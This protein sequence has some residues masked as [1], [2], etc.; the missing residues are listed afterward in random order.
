MLLSDVSQIFVRA[1]IIHNKCY[2]LRIKGA[3]VPEKYQNEPLANCCVIRP[4]WFVAELINYCIPQTKA[5]KLLCFPND[6]KWYFSLS[7]YIR[8]N[9]CC[10]SVFSTHLL[11]ITYCFS[12]FL[13]DVCSLWKQF[14]DKPVSSLFNIFSGSTYAVYLSA[15]SYP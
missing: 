7:V 9:F 4:C 5:S 2:R 11:S 10:A 1:S 14:E 8:A 13:C 15:Y 12:L 6:G 3:Y